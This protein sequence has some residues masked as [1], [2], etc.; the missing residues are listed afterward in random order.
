MVNIWG[1]AN[2]EDFLYSA[3]DVLQSVVPAICWSNEK[4]ID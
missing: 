3:F 4:F 2:L 1:K